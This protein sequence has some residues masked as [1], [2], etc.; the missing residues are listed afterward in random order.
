VPISIPGLFGSSPGDIS[1]SLCSNAIGLSLGGGPTSWSVNLT[2]QSVTAGV[3]ADGGA[4]L[5]FPMDAV[6]RTGSGSCQVN[7]INTG[8]GQFLGTATIRL[9]GSGGGC[10]CND[11]S[12]ACPAC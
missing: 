2:D 7:A 11:A 1:A 5:R 4:L 6:G 8:T 9:D 3:S 10:K 12:S